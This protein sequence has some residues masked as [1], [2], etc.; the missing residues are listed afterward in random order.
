MKSSEIIADINNIYDKFR[1]PNNLREHM[2]RVASVAK[3]IFDNWKGSEINK[4]DVLA[5]C[6]LHDL[7]NIVKFDFQNHGTKIMGDEASKLNYWRK[8]KQEVISRYGIEDT[9]VTKKMTEEIG[10]SDRLKFLL[11]HQS[12]LDNKNVLESN[13]FEIKIC[14]YA[15]YRVGPFGILSVR[16]R[17]DEFKKR[18]S[19]RH[20]NFDENKLNLTIKNALKIEEQIFNNVKIKPEDINNQIIKEF[21]V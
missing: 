1:I 4:E 2:F 21:K 7:G 10:I 13:D 20:I 11:K 12:F 18:Y 3:I 9:E 17:L 19:E 5:V 16:K 14:T 15:D 8:V 6:L